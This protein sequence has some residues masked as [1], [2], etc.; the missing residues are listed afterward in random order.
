MTFGDQIHDTPMTVQLFLLGIGLICGGSIVG[1][2]LWL[3]YVL[4]DT[5]RRIAESTLEVE[6]RY[7]RQLEEDQER[8]LQEARSMSF[9]RYERPDPSI[10]FPR[11]RS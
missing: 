7:I 4:C 3:K 8:R 2:I 9:W 1:G 6:R 5:A 11:R 10:I